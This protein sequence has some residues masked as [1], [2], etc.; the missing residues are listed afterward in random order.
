MAACRISGW[1]KIGDS[2]SEILAIQQPALNA[3]WLTRKWAKFTKN[4]PLRANACIKSSQL[5]IIVTM[6]KPRE[7]WGIWRLKRIKTTPP[8]EPPWYF[9]RG[10]VKVAVIALQSLY[11]DYG[12]KWFELGINYSAMT[13]IGIRRMTS[14]ATGPTTL[15][16]KWRWMKP[17]FQ[18][19]DIYY[20]S[21]YMEACQEK[22]QY[23]VCTYPIS[24]EFHDFISKP[25]NTILARW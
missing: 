22:N 15:G 10:R 9:P 25:I 24:P 18:R 12:W 2:R 16:M 4:P 3:Y 21:Q 14:G 7:N 17:S 23:V 20:L 1:K 6:L 13:S 8:G 5:T 19:R 11:V